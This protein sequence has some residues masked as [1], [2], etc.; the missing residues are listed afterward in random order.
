MPVQRT[1]GPASLGGVATSTWVADAAKDKLEAG[2]AT[3]RQFFHH[4]PSFSMAC[5]SFLGRHQ[6]GITHA[7]ELFDERI[8]QR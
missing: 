5:Q 6:V 3:S 2:P 4:V 1:A 8:N 7:R